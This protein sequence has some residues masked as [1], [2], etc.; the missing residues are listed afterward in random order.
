MA[1]ACLAAEWL[2]CS[3]GMSALW[4]VLAVTMTGGVVFLGLGIVCRIPEA[5]SLIWHDREDQFG[6]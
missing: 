1:V 4:Q 3:R 6:E 2:V 5:H